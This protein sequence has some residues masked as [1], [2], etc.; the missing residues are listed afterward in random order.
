[1]IDLA[2]LISGNGSNLQAII[3]AIAAGLPAKIKLVI[4]DKAE[5][6]GLERARLA[7]IPTV[8]IA[9][10]VYPN[11]KS[12]DLALQAALDKYQPNFIILAGFMRILGPEFVEHYPN[13]ILNIHPALLP[14]YPGLN[15]HQAVLTAGDPLHGATVHVVT[16][17]LDQGPIIAQAS[18]AVDPKEDSTSLQAKVHRLEHR[19]YPWVIS[20]L[21]ADRLQLTAK[22]IFLDGQALPNHGLQ[23]NE[24]DKVRSLS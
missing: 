21:A 7:G 22:G 9:R 16:N 18:I 13:H 6:Y 2:V 14:K 11:R 24:M 15:T 8:V 23:L 12:F 20:L 4:S 5:A 1:M 17:D 19:L 3:D 10:E